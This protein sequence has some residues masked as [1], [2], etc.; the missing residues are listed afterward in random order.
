M[1]TK[2][3][4]S[5]KFKIANVISIFV[6]IISII[7]IVFKG[8]NYGIDFKGGTLIEL[9][10]DNTINVTS[11]IRSSLNSLNLGDVNV[12]EF[13]KNGDYLVK[14]EQ[15]Q[16]NNSNLIPLIKE[17]LKKNL[18]AEIN[19]R[20]VENVG[21]KVSSELLKSGIIAISLSLAAMLFYIWIR[22]EWQFSVG[23][24]M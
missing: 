24:M 22:F 21:P 8:L 23:S 16:E 2:I 5:S 12:K 11:K 17:T 18:N 20:R 9:R 6:F 4:F 19:F 3:D 15:K 14:V 13:G 7:F 10:T 1:I